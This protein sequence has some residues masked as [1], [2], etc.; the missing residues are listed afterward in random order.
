MLVFISLL[1]KEF[2]GPE[3]F[4]TDLE[5]DYDPHLTMFYFPDQENVLVERFVDL[6]KEI[7]GNIFFHAEAIAYFGDGTEMV[8]VGENKHIEEI[9]NSLDLSLLPPLSDKYP[10]FVPHVT[11]G[12]ITQPID[13]LKYPEGSIE[14]PFDIEFD[15][16]SISFK[17]DEFKII[18]PLSTDD[19]SS[20]D[21]S[22]ELAS[23]DGSSELDSKDDSNELD[24]Y[25]KYRQLR[26]LFKSSGGL[27]SDDDSQELGSNDELV[28]DEDDGDLP[29]NLIFMSRFQA[30]FKNIAKLFS[31]DVEELIQQENRGV[32]VGKD[33]IS[34]DIAGNLNIDPEVRTEPYLLDGIIPDG[35][36]EAPNPV[37]QGFDKQRKIANSKKKDFCGPILLANVETGDRR[38]ILPGAITW[39]SLPLNF[40]FLPQRTEG[41]NNAML[42]GA[43]T[44]ISIVPLGYDDIYAVVAEG[45]FSSNSAGIEAERMLAEGTIRTV[46]ADMDRFAYQVSDTG[47]VIDDG[48]LMIVTKCRIMGCTLLP[49]SAF[50]ETGIWL[51]DDTEYAITASGDNIYTP[52]AGIMTNLSEIELE[53]SSN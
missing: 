24:R 35:M 20:N 25:P 17:D 4:P 5:V 8:Y 53:Q 29:D 10:I 47:S 44:D 6:V 52:I 40:M 28:S 3:H 14:I 48:P 42:C 9:R 50:E 16:I 37:Q 2:H 13:R 49:F 21:G 18:L 33:L 36:L 39:R 31:V 45:F 22:Q 32:E 15:R 7:K 46:S 34:A 12:N 30:E 51:M 11:F 43:I 19:E 27:A 41:H 26:K 23:R 1:P 38:L